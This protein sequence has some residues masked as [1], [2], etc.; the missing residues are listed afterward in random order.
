MKAAQLAADR[1]IR[2]AAGPR[3]QVTLLYRLI[4]GRLPSEQEMALARDFIGAS[5]LEEFCRALFN[6]NEFVYVR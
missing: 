4:L 2:E 1:V 5:P 6:L 3:E